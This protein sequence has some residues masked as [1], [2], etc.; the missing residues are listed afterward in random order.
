MTKKIDHEELGVALRTFENVSLRKLS[1]VLDVSYPALLKASKAPVAGE[2]YNPD[3]VNVQA[4]AEALNKRDKYDAYMDLDWVSLDTSNSSRA[5]LVKDHSE[6]E[7]GTLVWLR[8]DN[9]EPFRIIYKTE[10]HIVLQQMSSTEPI[11][12]QI[13]TFM[14]NGPSK[15]QRPA[16]PAKP[17]EVASV[18]LTEPTEP[19]EA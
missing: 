17:A 14:L 12:W 2:P 11:C 5:F 16:K 7:I 6:F 9:E 18:E 13:S 1:Q 8:K 4:I 10:T 15:T 3:Y 19:T